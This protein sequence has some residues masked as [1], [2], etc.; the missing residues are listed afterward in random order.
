[1]QY[2]FEPVGNRGLRPISIGELTRGKTPRVMRTSVIRR[3][4]Y[5]RMDYSILVN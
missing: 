3:L 2:G 4:I 5:A 1:M